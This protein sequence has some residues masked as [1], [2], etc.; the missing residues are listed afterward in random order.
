MPVVFGISITLF[1][2]AAYGAVVV[3]EGGLRASLMLAAALVAICVACILIGM[4]L[5]TRWHVT[6]AA[7]WMDIVLAWG[8]TFFSGV[9]LPEV[10]HTYNLKTSFGMSLAAVALLAVSLVLARPCHTLGAGLRHWVTETTPSPRR[11]PQEQLAQRNIQR[12]SRRRP[13]EESKVMVGSSAAD[14]RE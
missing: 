8:T 5:R 2:A 13:R 7:V 11:T 9:A 3:A 4:T 12:S 1:V 14:D 6:L 10:L